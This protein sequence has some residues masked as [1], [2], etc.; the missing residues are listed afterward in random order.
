MTAILDLARGIVVTGHRHVRTFATKVDLR[1]FEL[2]VFIVERQSGTLK[3]AVGFVDVGFHAGGRKAI[4]QIHGNS[5]Q[6]LRRNGC[7]LV[8]VRIN[9]LQLVRQFLIERIGL[10]VIRV[11]TFVVAVDPSQIEASDLRLCRFERLESRYRKFVIAA[12]E[13]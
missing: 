3:I 6:R 7:Q 10:A 13:S 8:V 2:G 11:G 4:A 9:V 5:G 1:E 12:V